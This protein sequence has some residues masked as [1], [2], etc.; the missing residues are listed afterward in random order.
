MGA[1]AV[2]IVVGI[3]GVVL[4]FGIIVLSAVAVAGMKIVSA[5]H[6]S[7]GWLVNHRSRKHG[8]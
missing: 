5:A 7:R 6:D 1:L 4:V 3:A 2:A 8:G